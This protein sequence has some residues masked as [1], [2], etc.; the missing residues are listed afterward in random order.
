M[1]YN[2]GDKC[3]QHNPFNRSVYSG[4]SKCNFVPN[5]AYEKEHM[6][7]VMPNGMVYKVYISDNGQY[8]R[9]VLFKNTQVLTGFCGLLFEVKTGRIVYGE[10]NPADRG[11]GNYKQLKALTHVTT[12]ACLWSDFQS[13][14]LLKA[15]GMTEQ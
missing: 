11:K 2:N 3:K 1:T 8:M 10:T 4:Q 12:K 7:D 5:C 9:A 6:S 14:E 13:A 15:A